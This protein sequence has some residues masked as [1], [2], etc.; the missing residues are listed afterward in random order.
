MTLP[1]WE[2]LKTQA[3]VEA[4]EY[5]IYRMEQDNANEAAIE[6]YMKILKEIDPESNYTVIS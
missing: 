2:E 1:S 3:I 6:L 5:Y 4:L